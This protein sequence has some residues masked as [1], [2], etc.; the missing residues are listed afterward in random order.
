[1]LPALGYDAMRLIFSALARSGTADPARVARAAAELEVAGA[2]GLFRL[3][4]GTSTVIRR[5]LIRAL[6]D[7]T[8]RP[9]DVA[10]LL[11]WRDAEAEEAARRA[12][13]AEDEGG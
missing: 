1:M 3:D 7:G 6:R 10:S 9:L 5:T 2:T 4:P 11:Q 13:A 8:L 12:E